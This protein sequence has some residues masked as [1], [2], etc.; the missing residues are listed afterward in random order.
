[1][2]VDARTLPWVLNSIE[3]SRWIAEEIDGLES[4]HTLRRRLAGA[5]FSIAL[6]H[7]AAIGILLHN[8]RAAPAFALLR[9]LFEAYVRGRWLAE[10]ASEGDLT[11]VSAGEPLP[12]IDIIL[13]AV[14]HGTPAQEQLLSRSKSANWNALCDFT[15]TG[16]RHLQ[17]Y[18]SADGI[19]ATHSIDEIQEALSFAN[20]MA[21]LSAL[22]IATLTLHFAL[23]ERLLEKSRE[24][25]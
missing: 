5:S 21:L 25:S 22:G 17:R 9:V 16:G 11:R 7:H 6:D 19:E 1:M 3:L 18:Q 8:N 23:A 24:F 4:I 10:C 14:E 20:A 15:H 12:K 2:A 13:A